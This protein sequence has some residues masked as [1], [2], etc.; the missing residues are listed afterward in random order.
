MI[1]KN[2]NE[3][4]QTLEDNASGVQVGDIE[5]MNVRQITLKLM[6]FLNVL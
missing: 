4:L 3:S 1:T 2:S 5:Q 6:V